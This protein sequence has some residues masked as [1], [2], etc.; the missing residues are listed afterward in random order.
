MVFIYKV[1]NGEN[2]VFNYLKKKKIVN[3]F[4][5]G[6]YKISHNHFYIIFSC[7][8]LGIFEFKNKIGIR[9]EVLD[10]Y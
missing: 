5:R 1:K 6:I 4:L 3:Y 10:I 9:Y 8:R 2:T 7:S